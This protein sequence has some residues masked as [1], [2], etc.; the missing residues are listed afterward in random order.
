MQNF[1]TFGLI[2]KKIRNLFTLAK[3]RRSRERGEE[4]RIG[5]ER[6]S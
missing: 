2:S 4:G 1:R 5:R 3:V 6:N